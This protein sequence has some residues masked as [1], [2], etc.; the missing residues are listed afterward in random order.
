MSNPTTD[1]EWR[2][3]ASAVMPAFKIGD[4]V[5]LIGSL[6]RGV[7]VY[8]QQVRAHNLMW[9]LAELDKAAGRDSLEIAIIGGG[10]TGLTAAACVLSL[11]PGAKVT[12]FERSY[13][14]CSLQQG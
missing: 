14:L 3:H 1:D 9:A 2:E 11:S 6:E 12:V 10:I 4:E 5:Y 8:G 7:T 13:D